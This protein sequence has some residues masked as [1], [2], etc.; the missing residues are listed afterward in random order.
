MSIPAAHSVSDAVVASLGA[1]S[2]AVSAMRLDVAKR[3]RPT[4]SF[5]IVSTS[6]AFGGERRVGFGWIGTSG[7]WRIDVRAVGAS[8]QA[9]SELVRRVRDRLEFNNL[10]VGSVS[11]VVAFES[12]DAVVEDADISGFSALVTFTVTL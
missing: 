5:C 3:D 10:T 12:G 11:G 7:S 1:A 6:P 9:A 8:E 2:P 4:E